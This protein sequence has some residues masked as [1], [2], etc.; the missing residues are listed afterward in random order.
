MEKNSYE[1]RA[2]ESVE[3]GSPSWVTSQKWMENK[4]QAVKV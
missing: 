4:I 1:R 2:H 3:D